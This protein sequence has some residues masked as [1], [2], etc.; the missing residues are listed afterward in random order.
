SARPFGP[1]MLTTIAPIEERRLLGIGLTLA[2]YFMFTCIDSSAKW[3]SLAGIAAVQVVFLRYAIHL[4]LVLGIH[5]PRSGFAL[6]RTASLRTQTLR[7]ATLLGSTTCN[8]I[9][10]RYLPLTVTAAIAFTM[11]LMLCALSVPML[12]ETVGRRRWSAIIIGF[13]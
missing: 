11:P 1:A 6:V 2:A 7:A 8:F 5:V 13:L 12:G 10:L 9:A 4:V 3:L